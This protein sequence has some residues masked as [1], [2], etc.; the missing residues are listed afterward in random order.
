MG[1]REAIRS[2]YLSASAGSGKTFALSQRFCR[3]I[4]LGV[5]PEEICAL[6]FTRLATR[7]IF[8]AVV[9]RF[10]SGEVAAGPG[11]LSDEVALARLLQALPKLQIFT[12]DAFLSRLAKLFSYELGLN[13]DFSLYEGVGSPE[14][15]AI[16]REVVM[17]ALRVTPRQSAEALL[18]SFDVQEDGA[19]EV[20]ALPQR[21]MRFFDAYE[22]RLAQTPTGWG[23]LTRLG[24]IPPVA[25]D[26]VAVWKTLQMLLKRSP[27]WAML[28]ES[29][30]KRYL[31]TVTAYPAAIESI[32]EAMARESRFEKILLQLQAWERADVSTCSSRTR[33]SLLRLDG[34]GRRAVRA[35]VDDAIGRDLAQAA[36]HTQALYLAVAALHEAFVRDSERSGRMDFG[37]LTHA[38][39]EALGGALSVRD[40]EKLYVAYRLDA[41]IRHLMIDEFQDT[42]TA[43]WRALSSMAHELATDPAGSFFYVGD[44]KQSIYGWRGGDSTLFGDASRVPPVP[45]GAPLVES[46]RARPAVV[47]LINQVFNFP[48]ALEEACEPWQKRVLADWRA[49]WQPHIAHAQESAYAAF[50]YVPGNKAHWLRTLAEDIAKRWHQLSGRQLT[51][52]V[53]APR[54]SLFNGT[55]EEPGLALLLRNL[56]VDCAVEGKRRVADTPLG[57]L[58]LAMLQWIADPR[59]TRWGEVARRTGLALGADRT[60]LARWTRRIAADGWVAWLADCFGLGAPLRDKL[61]SYDLACLERVRACFEQEDARGRKDPAEMVEAL[62]QAEELCAAG[63]QTLRLMTIHHSK[64]LTFDVVFTVLEGPFVNEARVQ[65]EQTP[66]WL[67]EKPALDLTYEALLALEEARRVRKEAVFRDGL[68]GLYVAL[69]RAKY[70]QTVYAVGMAVDSLKFRP[71]WVWQQLA[72]GVK[73]CRRGEAVEEWW[74][75]GDA[76][77]WQAAPLRPPSSPMPS[78]RSWHSRRAAPAPQ[79]ELPAEQARAATVAELLSDVREAPRT[80]GLSLHARLA[81]VAWSH[82]PP[83]GLFPEVFRQPDEPC[84]L[85]RER[86]FSVRLT[87][88]GPLH[89][90]AGQFDRVHLFP[91]TRRAVIYDFKSGASAELTP[92]YCRQMQDYRLALARLT[93]YPRAAIR[94]VLLFTRQRCAVEVPDV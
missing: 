47:A 7:E 87:E 45:A 69:T 36:A 72:P 77:W 8:T 10:L 57:S 14:G 50:R 23:D 22:G 93:G 79:V 89:Y 70:E 60:I 84:E 63:S 39:G 25:A 52:A 41:A 34:E 28:D 40:P 31:E 30:Q 82:S 9:S 76:A 33:K 65:C 59:A 16:L 85:W 12:I 17:G 83:E 51:M 26:R 61:T 54:N 1:A 11:A 13:P 29:A 21:L 38:L 6:T 4:C 19:A 3:L 2:H 49:G 78:K 81:A 86:A 20:G 67:L 53:L 32:R 15:R 75:M 55:D 66:D 64:G 24:D 71:G 91:A 48:K 94:C 88:S 74:N 46:Y 62:S 18:K 43:Q 73:P 58:T 42:S 90:M 37:Q 80:Q 27:D 56:G 35:L 44:V 68:C 5:A 92:A